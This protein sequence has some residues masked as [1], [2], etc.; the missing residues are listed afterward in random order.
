MAE[1]HPGAV[2]SAWTFDGGGPSVMTVIAVAVVMTLT[3]GTGAV[4]GSMITGK[5]IKKGTITS[6]HL[7]NGTVRPA[8]LSSAAKRRMTGPAGPEGA[9]ERP[10]L[11]DRK[12]LRAFPGRWA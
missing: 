4:A 11:R 5:Q 6:K 2:M 1:E 9:R 10:V 3:A 8:D 7:K 12:G